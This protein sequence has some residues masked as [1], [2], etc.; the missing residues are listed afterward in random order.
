MFVGVGIIER[1]KKFLADII[2]LY[3]YLLILGEKLKL[4]FL[5]KI[6]IPLLIVL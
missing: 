1:Q 3:G 2:Q 4:S 5:L 6:G